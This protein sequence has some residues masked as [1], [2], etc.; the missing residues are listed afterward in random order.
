[1]ATMKC[2]ACNAAMAEGRASFREPGFRKPK[3]ALDRNVFFSTDRDD[4]Q[5][6]ALAATAHYCN[7]CSTLVLAGASSSE[8]TCFE[9][10]TPIGGDDDACPAC[11]WSW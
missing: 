11:G 6:V 4:E 5:R 10:G 8:F 9:C 7:A 3:F 1:M 2:P